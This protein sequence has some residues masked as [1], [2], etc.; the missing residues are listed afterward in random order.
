MT[1]AL[2]ADGTIRLDGVCPVGDAEPLLRLV[3]ND[4][5]A[6]V[7]WRGCTEAH[8]A[9]IQILLAA[10]PKLLGPPAN[11]FLQVRVA[12]LIASPTR[13]SVPK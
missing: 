5:D 9:V 4:R 6:L 13:I 10:A 2:A 1:V 7:D 8:A 11:Q 3:T 12:P